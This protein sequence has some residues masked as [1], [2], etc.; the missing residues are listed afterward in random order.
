MEKLGGIVCI[1]II[2]NDKNNN[3]NNN[4]DLV[5][6]NMKHKNSIQ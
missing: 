1:N 4:E 2:N 6:S 3:K 5:H